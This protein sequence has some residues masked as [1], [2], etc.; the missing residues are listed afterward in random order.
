MFGRLALDASPGLTADIGTFSYTTRRR[1]A[2]SSNSPPS[3]RTRGSCTATAATGPTCRWLRRR[4][5]DAVARVVSTVA[6]WYIVLSVRPLA[7]REAS[8][9]SREVRQLMI[10][11][12]PSADLLNAVTRFDRRL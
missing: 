10:V 12:M 7:S 11:R 5:N 3:G 6:R 9:A 8:R 4:E 1:S 2:G